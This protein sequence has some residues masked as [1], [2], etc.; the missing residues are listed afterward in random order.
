MPNGGPYTAN[1]ITVP[2]LQTMKLTLKVC[3]LPKMTQWQDR[4]WVGEENKQLT[5][6]CQEC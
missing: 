3:N 2:T 4:K 5:Q 6:I 1:T